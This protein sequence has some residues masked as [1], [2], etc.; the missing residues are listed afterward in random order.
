MLPAEGVNTVQVAAATSTGYW[1]LLLLAFYAFR[2]LAAACAEL[3]IISDY[4]KHSRGNVQYP[5]PQ[6]FCPVQYHCPQNFGLATSCMPKTLQRT[7]CVHS[8]P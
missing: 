5:C 3:L 7:Y 6:N 1:L 8:V 4:P 2:M